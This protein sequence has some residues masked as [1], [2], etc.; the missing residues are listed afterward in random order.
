VTQAIIVD[1]SAL[2]V[3]ERMLKNYG[4]SLFRKGPRFAKSTAVKDDADAEPR[5]CIEGIGVLFETPILNKR[6][7]TIV[8]EPTA[9]DIYFSSGKRPDFWFSHDP[10]KVFGSNTELCILKEGVA[11]RLPLTNESYASTVKGMIESGEQASVSIGFTELKTRNEVC[12]G[13]PVKFIEEA[14]LVEVSLVPVGAC[15][16]A[17]ARLID[18]NNEPPLHESVNTSMFAIEYGMHNIKVI[19]KDNEAEIDRIERK[20]SALQTVI[21]NDESYLVAPS[22]TVDQCNRIVSGRYDQLRTKQRANLFS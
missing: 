16:Q 3:R 10:T 5:L 17:F 7:E 21:D 19:R 14:E 4:A 15:K 20:L 13:H 12:F 22:M 11:F 8:F 1:A 6:G 9:F 2:R 18:A